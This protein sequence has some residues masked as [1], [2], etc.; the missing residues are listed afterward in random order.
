MPIT[1]SQ[2]SSHTFIRIMAHLHKGYDTAMQRADYDL[3]A[4]YWNGYAKC[5]LLKFY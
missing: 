2:A 5:N 3:A 1:H 4:Y